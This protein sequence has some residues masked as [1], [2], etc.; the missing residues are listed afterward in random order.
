MIKV[1]DYAR[2][3]SFVIT[4]TNQTNTIADLWSLGRIMID[5]LSSIDKKQSLFDPQSREFFPNILP[6]GSYPDFIIRLCHSLLSPF[7][8]GRISSAQLISGPSWL[9]ERNTSAETENRLLRAQLQAAEAKIQ[10]L[11]DQ[12]EASS[13]KVPETPP[14][15]DMAIENKSPLDQLRFFHGR[16][17]MYCLS[18][19]SDPLIGRLCC[20]VSTTSSAPIWTL[21]YPIHVPK[22]AIVG[23]VGNDWYVVHDLQVNCFRAVSKKYKLL[24]KLFQP[25]HV[26]STS[27]AVVGSSIFAL[28]NFYQMIEYRTHLRIIIEHKGP[29]SHHRLGVTMVSIG[30]DIYAL[31]GYDGEPVINCD[32]Y[33]IGTKEWTSIAPL[34]FGRRGGC[35]VVLNN[36]EIWLIGSGSTKDINGGH[37]LSYRVSTN[38]WKVMPFD[39]PSNASTTEKIGAVFDA[40]SECLFVAISNLAKVTTVYCC[41]PSTMT[42]TEQWQEICQGQSK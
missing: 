25:I 26:T 16:E 24:A 33:R 27:A 35:A 28:N 40:T 36:D 29:V 13:G 9:H 20:K 23:L 8:E 31:G 41:Q 34:P 4:P 6:V 17:I 18:G 30:R 21:D 14:R 1:F 19:S 5:M 22:S 15:R 38:K 2:L 10:G 7:A 12:L 32:R 11:R 37:I 3:V 42:R 39:C